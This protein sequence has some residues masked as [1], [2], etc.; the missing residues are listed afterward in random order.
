MW[1]RTLMALLYTYIVGNIAQLLVPVA[2]Y[3]LADLSSRGLQESSHTESIVGPGT[4]IRWP[5]YY[6][7]LD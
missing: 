1:L 5:F 3:T 7:M 2:I 4:T 6:D